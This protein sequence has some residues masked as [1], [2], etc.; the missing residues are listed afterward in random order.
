[1]ADAK[2]GKL[3]TQWT[4]EDL[5]KGLLTIQPISEFDADFLIWRN[6]PLRVSA[7]TLKTGEAWLK[8]VIYCM[9][10]SIKFEDDVIIR[11]KD[12]GCMLMQYI[13]ISKTLVF[14]SVVFKKNV[15]EQSWYYERDMSKSWISIKADLETVLEAFKQ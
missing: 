6:E 10:E 5:K 1:M 11:L 12:F 8:N 13:D 3:F 4:V 15:E 7:L 9:G 14:Q 2:K